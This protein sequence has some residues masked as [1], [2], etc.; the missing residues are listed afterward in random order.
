MHGT[1]TTP[2]AAG[3]GAS[4]AVIK[5]LTTNNSAACTVQ[6]ADGRTP[7]HLACDSSCKLF[8]DDLCLP[9][10]PPSFDTIRYLLW[11][12]LD[13]VT[14]E[15]VDEMCALEYAIMSDSSAEVVKLLQR[16]AQRVLKKNSRK[17]GR[18]EVH[19]FAPMQAK[20]NAV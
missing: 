18:Q 13:A 10:D 6:D 12:S 19:L 17:T 20:V 4:P 15:D 8:E 3:S 2:I 7:L 11:G 14:L 16:A 1:N 9:R 5:L